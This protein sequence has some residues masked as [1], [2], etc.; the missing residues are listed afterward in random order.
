MF[1]KVT[2]MHSGTWLVWF[3]DLWSKGVASSP[4]AMVGLGLLW[5]PS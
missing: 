3:C 4:E 5:F 1:V 2:E